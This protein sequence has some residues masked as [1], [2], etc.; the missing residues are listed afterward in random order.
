LD[1]ANPGYLAFIPGGGL[2]TSA[3]ADF[4]ACVTNRF[5]NLAATAPALVALEASTIRWLCDTFG[6]PAAAQGIFTSGGSMAN[7][8]ALVTAR[9]ER[10]PEDFLGGTLYVSDQAH[11][12]V[13]KAARLAGFPSGA[14]RVLPTGAD[15]TLDPD[16]VRAPV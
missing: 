2:F 4:L 12:S 5:V 8:S 15:L 9:V 7:F 1:P 6:L 13:V 10:L 11:Q 14:V 3:V 16:A